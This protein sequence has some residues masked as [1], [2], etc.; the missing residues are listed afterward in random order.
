[1]DDGG[2]DGSYSLSVFLSCVFEV[3]Y[4]QLVKRQRLSL[5]PGG[6]RT[7]SLILWDLGNWHLQE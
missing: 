3:V 4:L 6:M 2:E 5:K 1:M 7:F